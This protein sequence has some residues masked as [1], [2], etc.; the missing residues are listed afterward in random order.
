MLSPVEYILPHHNQ[1]VPN[2]ADITSLL[3]IRID[4]QRLIDDVTNAQ[5]KHPFTKKTPSWLSIPLRSAN[6]DIGEAGSRSFGIH[7]S[8]DVEVFKDTE[9][10]QYTP[11]IKKILDNIGCNYLKVRIMKLVAGK[12]IAEHIDNFQSDDIIRVHIPVITHP[13]VEFWVEKD[14]YFIPTEKLTYINV[15]RRHKVINRSS[16]DRIH[17]VIDIKWD[18][19]FR[20]RFYDALQLQ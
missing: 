15:R 12:A 2:V 7:N 4:S 3:T 14:N 18:E 17:L 9:I 19:N 1:K 20:K 8:G 11:Y 16:F 6:G 5:T 10:M 13:L